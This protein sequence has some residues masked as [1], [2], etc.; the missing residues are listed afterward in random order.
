MNER[1]DLGNNNRPGN[2]PRTEKFKLN[3]DE[4]ELMTG[5]FDPVGRSAGGRTRQTP[6]GEQYP[7]MNS[8]TAAYMT[9]EERRRERKAARQRNRLKARKNK[10]VFKWVWLCMV[11]LCAFT[12]ASYLIGGSNDFFG[13]GRNPGTTQVEVPNDLTEDLLAQILYERGA[14]KKP[15]FFA[16]YCKVKE[17][18][19]DFPAGTFEVETDLDYE[20]LINM[21]QGGADTREVVTVTFPEGIDILEAARLLDESGVCGA[22][23]FLEAVNSKEFGD[24]DEIAELTNLDA[25]YYDLEGYLFPDTY[26]FYVGEDLNSVIGKLLWNFHSKMTD[27]M[28][29]MIADSGMSLDEVIT[30]ASIIQAE[31]ADDSDMYN[32][33]AVLHNR[34]DFGWDY[35]IPMLQ[36]DSTI[37]YPYRHFE[38]VPESGALP[39]GAYDTYEING[40]PAG[41][42]C[43]PGIDAIM[44]ALS[45]ASSEEARRYLYFCHD[46]DGNAYYATNESDHLY[47]LQLA[48]LV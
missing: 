20:G 18:M 33:S 30:M 1:N 38:D 23:E 32:V 24:Y 48:G 3:I 36:C 25:R 46:A 11:L 40:L 45:P 31:A 28:R 47:N 15:E 4:R 39:Y 41:P 22:E 27:T 17:D 2:V 29:T 7:P 8:R 19:E 35:G 6:A 21:L 44:A 12:L 34:L 26:D 16:L 37:Y 5:S 10:R 14:I 43:N 13:V 9:E 42:I